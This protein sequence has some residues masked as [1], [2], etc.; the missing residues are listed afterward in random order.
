MPK[1]RAVGIEIYLGLYLK[2]DSHRSNLHKSHAS[3]TDVSK[4]CHVSA[5]LRSRERWYYIIKTLRILTKSLHCYFVETLKMACSNRNAC[6][7][8]VY[9]KCNKRFGLAFDSCQDVNFS[10]SSNLEIKHI[11]Y[12]YI[13]YVKMRKCH[14]TDFV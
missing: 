13:V 12:D 14:N 1:S 9:N 7:W 2:C 3:S 4:N 5:A 6:L 10:K 8:F 11:V